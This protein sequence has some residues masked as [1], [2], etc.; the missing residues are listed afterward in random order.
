MGS[1]AKQTYNAVGR[2][3]LLWWEPEALTIVTDKTSPLHD[4]DRLVKPVAEWMVQSVMT[5]GV[6][7]PILVRF[8]GKAEDGTPIVEV[9]NGRQRVRAA[10]EANKRLR[11]EGLEPIRV[12]GIIV[13]GT[14]N[15]MLGL[16]ILANELVELDTPLAK[17]RKAQRA[18]DGGLGV[19]EVAALFGVKD[20]TIKQWQA[21]LDCS[22]PV[23]QAV[24]SGELPPTTAAM[25]SKLPREEQ[26]LTLEKMRADGTL[27]GAS[28]VAA[29]EKAT[30]K[31]RGAR[32]PSE[33]GAIIPSRVW[34]KRLLA[35]LEGNEDSVG[36]RAAEEGGLAASY[37]SG[38]VA[39]LKL[40]LEGKKPRG[41]VVAEA[42][43]SVNKR[44][45]RGKASAEA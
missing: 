4:P 37:V 45:S 22:T 14:D 31:G 18:L 32:G 3:E 2:G 20:V 24:E 12:Q 44:F 8:N 30:G 13:R 36:F 10:M 17:A 38:A 9:V 35:E 43:R 21:L 15:D 41:N 1:N 28:G 16:M 42:W 6:K 40:A 34:L 11:K 39:V 25:L 5:K 23:Q 33:D 29:A 27:R 26:T 7:V 19:Q